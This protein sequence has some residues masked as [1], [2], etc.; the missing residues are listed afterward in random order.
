MYPAIDL[1]L[2]KKSPTGQIR[3]KNKKSK[4]MQLFEYC[5]ELMYNQTNKSLKFPQKI[6]TSNVLFNGFVA[7]INPSRFLDM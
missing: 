1:L 5:I 3:F 7:K 6:F 2:I 4:L